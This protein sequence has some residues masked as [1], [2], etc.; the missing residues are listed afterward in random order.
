[1][2]Q[3]PQYL[4]E[5]GNPIDAPE[6]LDAQGN[7]IPPSGPDWNVAPTLGGMAG[8]IGGFLLGGPIGAIAGATGGGALGESARMAFGKDGKPATLGGALIRIALGGIKQGTLEAI[9]QGLGRL[10]T[11]AAPPVMDM[12]LKR[13][14]AARLKFPN[15]P[16][17]LVDEGIIPA[18]QRVQKALSGTEAKINAE[19]TQF[20]AFRPRV[21]GY[22]P[23]ATESVALGPMPSRSLPS[24]AVWQRPMNAAPGSGAPP[25]MVDPG[26]IAD[27]AHAFA[28]QEGRVAGLGSAPGREHTELDALRQRYLTQNPRPRTLSE[29]IQQKRA[30]QARAKY[31]ARPNAPTVTNNELN[32]NEGIAAA[33]RAKAIKL[34][35]ALEG[36]LAKERDL[37]G[38]LEAQVNAES[39]AMPL[40]TVGTARTL[41]G[42]RNPTLMGRFAIGL[43]RAGRALSSPITPASVRAAILAL[44]E[45]SEQPR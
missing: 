2:P 28:M 4:D 14:A 26:E 40:S 23:A 15:T 35:P 21:A 6:A 12:G 27:E 1:M 7:P 19:A 17:R 37:L 33:N 44:M 38:A 25:R 8:G 10:F 16:N 34:N 32:F 18:G 36:D 39:K 31:S 41:L 30:Y 45:G 3:A 22:L 42:L 13:T 5:Q 43:D 9:P 11:K 29:T 24:P 20:D